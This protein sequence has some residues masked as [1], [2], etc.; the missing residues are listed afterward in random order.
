MI[1]ICSCRIATGMTAVR[2]RSTDTSA[3]VSEL[4]IMVGS[5]TNLVTGVDT[6]VAIGIVVEEILGELKGPG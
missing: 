4:V 6:I 2:I 5:E 1:S 3:V